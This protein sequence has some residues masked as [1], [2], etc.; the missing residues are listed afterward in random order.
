VQVYSVS[1]KW[2]RVSIRAGAP[3]SYRK[4]KSRYNFRLNEQSD[5]PDLHGADEQGTLAA[6]DAM[7]S[8][9][10]P[11]A[12]HLS[13]TFRAGLRPSVSVPDEKAYG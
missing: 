11:C 8:C 4:K 1:R 7:Q 13:P 3:R 6:T 9:T 12:Q 5:K 2:I 10:L